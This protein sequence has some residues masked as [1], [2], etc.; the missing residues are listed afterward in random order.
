MGNIYWLSELYAIYQIQQRK[1]PNIKSNIWRPSGQVVLKKY[2]KQIILCQV[3]EHKR[4][5]GNEEGD[6]STKQAIDYQEWSQ[7]DYPIQA[8][9][10]Q[11][12]VLL[13]YT[14]LK[15]ALKSGR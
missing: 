10:R 1:P 3:P 14:T 6:K 5:K 8:T 12:R 11:L 2:K 9:S 15:F 4:I 13:N 7:P